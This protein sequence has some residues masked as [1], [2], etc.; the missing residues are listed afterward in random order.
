MGVTKAP[1][2]RHQ[3]P[4]VVLCTDEMKKDLTAMADDLGY[5][6]RSDLVRDVLAG[7]IDA[8]KKK[9]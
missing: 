2:D 3:S 9:K 5:E 6:G 8:W 7:R 1:E 4:V